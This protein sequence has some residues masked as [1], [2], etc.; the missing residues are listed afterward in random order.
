MYNW[1]R[2]TE[3]YS[4]PNPFEGHRFKSAIPPRRTDPCTSEMWKIIQNVMSEMND[5]KL[6]QALTIG[7][8]TGLRPSEC[9]RVKASDFDHDHLE[10]RVRVTKTGVQERIIKIPQLLSN[11]A[12]R[13]TEWHTLHPNTIANK[14]A[15]LKKRHPALRF[16]SSESLRYAFHS[17]AMDA[18][19]DVRDVARHQGHSPV[20]ALKHYDR[21]QKPLDV[22]RFGDILGTDA[23]EAR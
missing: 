18:G 1:L 3:Q 22:E 14:V 17:R 15:A 2:D 12:Q 5:P 21:F 16:F 23:L 7:F 8:F 10:L 4:Q 11:W 6:E 20:V 9:Y 13:R 19:A